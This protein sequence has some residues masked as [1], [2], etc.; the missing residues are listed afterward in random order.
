MLPGDRNQAYESLT[1]TREKLDYAWGQWKAAKSAIHAR[2][3]REWE[4]RQQAKAARKA[5]G[6]RKHR[7]FVAHVTAHIATLEEK[8]DTARRGLD[9]QQRHRED[10][11][12]QYYSAWNDG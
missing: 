9:K 12:S 2:R 5:E 11:R 7:A 8:L 6:E 3:Q 1:Q 10:L 4:E